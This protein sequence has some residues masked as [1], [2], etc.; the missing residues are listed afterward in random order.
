MIEF[1]CVYYLKGDTSK[2]DFLIK[3]AIANHADMIFL[4]SRGRSNSA[5][6]L[7]GSFAEKIVNLNNEIPM[8]IFKKKREN[9]TFLE[10]LLKI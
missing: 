1:D 4:G 5:A 10:A 6:F 9:M 2:G 3:E 7:L 8:L